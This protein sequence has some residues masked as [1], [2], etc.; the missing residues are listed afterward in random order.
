M[1][2]VV[3]ENNPNT[4]LWR[5]HRIACI[6][7]PSGLEGR[8]EPLRIGLFNIM[9]EA[10]KYEFSIIR[11]LGLSEIP[12][13]PVWIRSSTHDYRSSDKEHL[14]K[15]YR[16]LEEA[17]GEG[18]LD[19][20]IITG[21]PVETIRFESV[22]YW[23]ELKSIFEYSRAN[24]ISTMGIC[25]GGL[26]IAKIFGVEKVTYAKKL[27][28]VY[29]SINLNPSH[30]VTGGFAGTFYCPH[31]RYAGLNEDDA[32]AAALA[33]RI[34]LLAFSEEAGY[35]IFE[36]SD[37]R[38]IGH[39]GHPEYTM[40]RI[41]FEHSRDLNK[42]LE[43]FPANFDLNNPRDNWSEGGDAFFIRWIEYIRSEKNGTA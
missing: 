17:V 29:R 40:E 28:G 38:F 31:S 15:W 19:G 43:S 24:I 2:L 30:P 8:P 26:A 12:V 9:P 20:L 41:L 3:P 16:P 33:G 1:P 23:E 27:F 5:E 39:T 32:R 13:A 14:K 37:R 7:D 25:W 11:P 22:T 34:N 4:P 6:V 21:A 35:F 10:E 36:S 42:G 18:P